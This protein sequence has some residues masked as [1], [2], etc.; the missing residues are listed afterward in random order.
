MKKALVFTSLIFVL[1]SCVKPGAS[2]YCECSIIYSTGSG[3]YRG[4]NKTK[5]NAEVDC[6]DKVFDEEKKGNTVNCEVKEK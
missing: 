6:K 4:A 2:Y 3:T 1:S 5:G